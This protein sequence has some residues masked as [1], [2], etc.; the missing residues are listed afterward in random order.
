[1]AP[2]TQLAMQP[3]AGC[4]VMLPRRMYPVSQPLPFR[5]T[6][7]RGPRLAVQRP[8][9]C[10]AA[11]SEYASPARLDKAGLD[12]AGAAQAPDAQNLAEPQVNAMF[13]ATDSEKEGWPRWWQFGRLLAKGALVV[14][15]AAALVGA[16]ACVSASPFLDFTIKLWPP[17]LIS[18]RHV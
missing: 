14:F 4:S 1:M 15:M 7:V 11:V 10:R 9:V 18:W 6:I 2:M 13:S 3:I 8:P 5:F 17:K 12:K 16:R